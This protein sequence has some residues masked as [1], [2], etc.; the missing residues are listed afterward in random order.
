[1]ETGVCKHPAEVLSRPANSTTCHHLIL[2]RK[3]TIVKCGR[4]RSRQSTF[5][6]WDTDLAVFAD[7]SQWFA[8]ATSVSIVVEST[9]AMIPG[10]G[11]FQSWSFIPR[12]SQ[13]FRKWRW[14]TQKHAL[15]FYSE[16]LAP[17][18]SP[19]D[20]SKMAQVLAWS[21]RCDQFK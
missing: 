19:T 17:Y 12:A 4:K 3:W 15:E 10:K 8:W 2:I 1:M 20:A 9:R 11:L 21:I 5:A 14:R 13:F 7:K 16:L 6:W 18:F